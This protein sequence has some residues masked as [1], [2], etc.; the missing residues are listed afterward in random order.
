M[1]AF[2][3]RYSDEEKPVVHP[4]DI[5]IMASHYSIAN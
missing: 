3:L 1:F 2:I 5:I 4:L